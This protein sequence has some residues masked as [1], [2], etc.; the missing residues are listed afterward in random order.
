MKTW[1]ELYDEC[2]SCDG[3]LR[4]LHHFFVVCR[5]YFPADA[6]AQLDNLCDL[7]LVE[8]NFGSVF[9]VDRSKCREIATK[10][11]VARLL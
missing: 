9:R 10:P 1:E 5:R 6:A 2:A 11:W 4:W 8:Y 7:H 3:I